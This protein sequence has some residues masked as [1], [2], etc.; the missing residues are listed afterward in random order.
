[1]PQTAK[2]YDLDLLKMGDEELVVLAQECEFRPAAD[3]LVLRYHEPIGRVIA[4]KARL[5]TLTARDVEDAQQNVFFALCE[6][7]ASYRTLEMAKPGGCRFRSYAGTVALARFWDFVK[8]VRRLQKRCHC[9]AE[10]A[11]RDPAEGI[12]RGSRLHALFVPRQ[13]CSDPTEAAARQEA[14]RALNQ[15]L[16]SLDH[17]MQ[18]LWQQLAA[19]QKL[20]QIAQERGLSYDALK[21][22]RRTLLSKLARVLKQPAATA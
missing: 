14:L 15:A 21:R 7:I 17:P 10:L 3:E 12:Q 1:M 5:T 13:H 20:R 16:Q 22:Q 18:A 8:R 2:K 19:G 4:H 9:R 6:A 11:G